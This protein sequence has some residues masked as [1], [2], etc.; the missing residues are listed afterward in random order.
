[1]NDIKQRYMECSMMAEWTEKPANINAT[2]KVTNN[3]IKK[4]QEEVK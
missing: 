3:L 1:M 4:L 2:I